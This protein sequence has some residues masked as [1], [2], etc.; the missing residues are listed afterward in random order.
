MLL[1]LRH[2]KFVIVTLGADG[3]IML[4]RHISGSKALATTYTGFFKCLL[5]KSLCLQVMY[6]AIPMFIL[7]KSFFEVCLRKLP[8]GNV[9]T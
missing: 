1:R 4:E 7:Q 6:V 2:A 8:V 9:P 5:V 3:C